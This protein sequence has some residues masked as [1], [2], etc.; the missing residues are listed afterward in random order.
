MTV[1]CVA[2]WAGGLWLFV[3]G[4]AFVGG[5]LI[6]IAGLTFIVVYGGGPRDMLEGLTAFFAGGGK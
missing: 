4:S 5:V 3:A 6:L 2:A 1:V